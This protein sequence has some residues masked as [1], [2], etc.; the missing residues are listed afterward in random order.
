MRKEAACEAAGAA[1]CT[2]FTLREAPLYCHFLSLFVTFCHFLSLFERY[3]FGSWLIPTLRRSLRDLLASTT[4]AE[5][6]DKLRN[7]Q[8]VRGG[9][10][11]SG[12]PIQA[13]GNL[14]GIS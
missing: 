6:V 1:S 12:R 4:S 5:I 10:G 13:R 14:A 8:N 3:L 9:G 7:S 2:C 11:W